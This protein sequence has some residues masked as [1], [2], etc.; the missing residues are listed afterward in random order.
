MYTIA[1]RHDRNLLDIR[2]RGL[3]DAA[4]V[5][6]YA[7]E[8]VRRFG[9]EGFAPGYRLRMDMSACSVQPVAAAALINSR[10]RDFPVASRIAIVTASAVT[11]L[12]VRRLMTQ[13]YLR[14]FDDA[15]TAFAWLVSADHDTPA[16]VAA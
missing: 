3:F 10:L 16:V 9:E 13:P 15:D 6:A 1:F 12:Q 8:L 5:D 7:T 14:I 11:R 2:W 4:A